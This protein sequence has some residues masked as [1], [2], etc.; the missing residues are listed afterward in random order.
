MARLWMTT[1]SRPSKRNHVLRIQANC[2]LQ[3]QFA[4]PHRNSYHYHKQQANQLSSLTRQ[5]YAA[6][7]WRTLRQG[8]RGAFALS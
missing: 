2:V 1:R 3:S 7:A 8:K 5:T 4:L 6:A